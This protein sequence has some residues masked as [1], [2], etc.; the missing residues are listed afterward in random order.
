MS[1]GTFSRGGAK[2][3]AAGTAPR[4]QIAILTGGADKPYAYGLIQALMHGAVTLDVIGNDELDCIEF[5]DTPHVNYLNL[6]GDQRTDAGFITKAFRVLK[7]YARLIRYS[8]TAQSKLFHILWNN[9]FEYFDRTILM[10]WYRFLGKGIVLTLH[11]VNARKRDRTD[12]ALNRLTLGIQYRLADHMFVHTERMKEQLIGEFAVRQER[13]TVIPF[14]INNAV[15]NTQITRSEA[16]EKLGLL[17]QEK[18]LL[19]FGNIAPYKGL[20]YLVRAFNDIAL[21]LDDYKLMIAGR[22][23]DCDHYWNALKEEMSEDIRNNK[24][25]IHQEYIPDEDTELYMKAADVLVLPYRFIYQSG[26]LFLGYSFG[27]PVLASEVGSLADEIVEGETG[28]IFRAEDPVDLVRAI[29][30]YFGSNLYAELEDRRSLIKGY[31]TARHS[32]NKVAQMT[33]EV[34]SSLLG[35]SSNRLIAK[36]EQKTAVDVRTN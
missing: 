13:I 31:A 2:S 34:Y 35:K 23:K 4:A 16:R 11:N 29:K 28:F 12:T 1:N 27:M 14:G 7:Y 36:N 33:L 3:A 17:S 8:V 22:P 20:E 18:V 24:I 15:P 25:I 26:V 5:R 30:Q 19:F 21:D 9:K 6:R 32:W 10:V